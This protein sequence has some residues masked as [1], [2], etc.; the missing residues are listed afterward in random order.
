[1]Q[2]KSINSKIEF[3]CPGCSSRNSEE[4]IPEKAETVCNNEVLKILSSIIRPY[5]HKCYRV[6]LNNHYSRSP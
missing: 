4:F 2:S 5:L 6:L 3:Q 1:M